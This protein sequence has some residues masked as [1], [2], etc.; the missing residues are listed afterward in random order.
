LVTGGINDLKQLEAYTPIMAK[1]ATASRSSFEDLG[2]MAV[3]LKDN[4]KIG[5]DGYE[6][7]MNR[8]SAAGKMGQC[9][10]ALRARKNYCLLSSK[11]GVVIAAGEDDGDDPKEKHRDTAEKK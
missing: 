5:A 6:E 3:A 2:K 10:R 11:S 8:M 7:A 1:S 4:L 9:Y